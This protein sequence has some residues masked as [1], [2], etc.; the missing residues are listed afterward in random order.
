MKRILLT[1]SVLVFAAGFATAEV[2]MTGDGVFGLKYDGNDTRLHY[3]LDFTVVGTTTTDSGIKFGA[4]FDLDLDDGTTENEIDDPEITIMSGPFSA[5]IGK[6]DSASDAFVTSLSDP[7]FDGIGVDD[8]VETYFND[9]D[10]NVLLKY[11]TD[12]FGV[13]LSYD[14]DDSNGSS[15]DHLSL[16]V[17]YE[18]SPSLKLALGYEDVGTAD[19]TSVSLSGN[20]A[21]GDSTGPA[22]SLGLTPLDYAIMGVFFDSG[23]STVQTFGASLTFGL[24]GGA[25]LTT[26]IGVDEDRIAIGNENDFGI[27]YKRP[28]GG[29]VS[30]AAG[31]GQVDGE[32]VGDFGVIFNF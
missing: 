8:G 3:E 15:T 23:G 30:V 13:G 11:Q 4:S 19:I 20:I 31:I 7:G 1:S 32:T 17:S 26:T 12:S 28:L 29:G 14:I 18:L 25:T 22:D 27:G 9:G 24:G 6:V 2:S 5:Y 10:Y 16:A 21:G